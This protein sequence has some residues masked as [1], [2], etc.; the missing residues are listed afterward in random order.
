MSPG[1]TPVDIALCRTRHF[2]THLLQAEKPVIPA[3]DHWK[4]KLQPETCVNA[5]EWKALYPPLINNK[6]GDVNWK[7]ALR[8][9]P[10]A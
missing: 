4:Q 6:H 9:F 8:V 1:Q 10:T 3:V 7:I 2:Y 5:T